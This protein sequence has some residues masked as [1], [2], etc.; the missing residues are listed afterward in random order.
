MNKIYDVK[1]NINGKDLYILEPRNKS[2]EIELFEAFINI[3]KIF[4]INDDGSKYKNKLKDFDIS[5][6]KKFG[7][8]WKFKV[9]KDSILV[10]KKVIRQ[11]INWG[12]LRWKL[13]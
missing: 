9:N 13:E 6:D 10:L 12:H 7:N 2:I 5:E 4:S 11:Y 3:G 8:I 1:V